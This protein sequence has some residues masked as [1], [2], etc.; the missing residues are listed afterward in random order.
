[1]AITQKTA[2]PDALVKF[3]NTGEGS[4]AS[5]VDDVEGST[6][7]DLIVD[8]DGDD[9]DDDE[10]QK[11]FYQH[12]RESKVKKMELAEDTGECFACLFNDENDE[13]Y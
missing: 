5:E 13:E 3:M 8:I 6:T 7:D 11:V 10:T 4:Q 9:N 2:K 12:D 1:M